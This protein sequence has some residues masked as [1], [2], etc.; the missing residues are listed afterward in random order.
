VTH[1]RKQLVA[2]GGRDDCGRGPGGAPD[3][4]VLGA[5]VGIVYRIGGQPAPQEVND[6]VIAAGRYGGQ[7]GVDGLVIFEVDDC[8]GPAVSGLVEGLSAGGP[9]NPAPRI[10]ADCT[11]SWPEPPAPRTSTVSPG[12][13]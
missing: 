10:R 4:D 13:R 7:A 9:D 6:H 11:A 5:Y 3:L 8:V 1:D 2:E 12:W